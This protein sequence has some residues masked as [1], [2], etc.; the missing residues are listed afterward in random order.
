ME[1]VRAKNNAQEWEAKAREPSENSRWRTCIS[2]VRS[3]GRRGRDDSRATSRDE[4]C[5]TTGDASVT[6]R[7][8]PGRSST[9]PFPP[10][11]ATRFATRTSRAQSMRPLSVRVMSV[12]L[13]MTCTTPPQPDRQSRLTPASRHCE[14]TSKSS[15][16]RD[17]ACTST[18][19]R[20][21]GTPRCYHT[22]RSY[23]WGPSRR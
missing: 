20:R 11:P 7:H 22:P 13:E 4:T 10:T 9:L 2:R 21:T 19:T 17:S 1:Y 14:I 6:T 5:W 23:R 12:S 3:W 15:S 16:A 8:P 18:R